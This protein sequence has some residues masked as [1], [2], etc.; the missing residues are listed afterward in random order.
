MDNNMESVDNKQGL[1]T[2]AVVL[3]VIL[4]LLVLGI[5]GWYWWSKIRTQTTTKTTTE[6]TTPT[7]T[8][9]QPT[10]TTDDTTGWKTY[11]TS[12]YSIKYPQDYFLRQQSDTLTQIVATKYK[13]YEGEFPYISVER[14]D[15]PKSL[16][17][18]DWWKEN[19]SKYESSLSEPTTIQVGGQ[20]A[21]KITGI[22]VRANQI[23]F[24]GYK[25]YVF[26][27]ININ[28]SDPN[29]DKILSTFQ[30]TP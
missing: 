4:V 27:I 15:N 17:L 28:S 7:I 11:K 26:D 25:T 24:M 9:T 3:I 21:L 18:E 6:T 23:I 5:G 1:S 14:K 30:F 13:N 20:K 2:T 19:K 8:T 16:S 12:D 10:T 29:Y 22:E